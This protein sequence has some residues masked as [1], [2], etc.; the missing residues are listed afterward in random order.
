MMLSDREE[1]PNNG[2]GD[3][4]AFRSRPDQA[5][6][7]DPANV[8]KFQLPTDSSERREWINEIVV[9]ARGRVG[10]AILGKYH[11]R[12]QRLVRL[13]RIGFDEL[14]EFAQEFWVEVI[15]DLNSRNEP[16]S[17]L[18][19]QLLNASAFDK[20]LIIRADFRAIDRIRSMERQDQQEAEAVSRNRQFFT[21]AAAFVG[22]MESPTPPKHSPL[23]PSDLVAFFCVRL[24]ETH[25]PL[26]LATSA[27]DSPLSPLVDWSMQRSEWHPDTI[28]PGIRVEATLSKPSPY[29]N[30]WGM[31]TLCRC[32]EEAQ[33]S[34]PPEDSRERRR[35][36]MN[37]WIGRVERRILML[38]RTGETAAK[39][40]AKLPQLFAER[41]AFMCERVK[42][43]QAIPVAVLAWAHVR[44]LT[45]CKR[46]HV[47]ALTVTQ[48]ID[49]LREG[50]LQ[51]GT[52]LPAP[53]EAWFR[54]IGTATI[55]EAAARL[56]L[57]LS[58]LIDDEEKAAESSRARA[59]YSR[60]NERRK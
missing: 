52:Q 11:F 51:R 7:D 24:C 19:K 47:G 50:L 17:T 30:V 3:R 49:E 60:E 12:F 46:A 36:I 33:I 26:D 57:D 54:K 14:E 35:R 21:A 55:E 41:H 2:S 58:K 4:S 16:G 22:V 31:V 37:Q 5:V 6:N 10:T 42:E 56:N 45:C 9:G 8:R 15:K 59:R 20:I 40:L 29:G 13:G 34:T 27:C 48:A 23:V 38:Q 43:E 18:E 28:P 25:T 32:I 1:K 53:M 44:L 39:I